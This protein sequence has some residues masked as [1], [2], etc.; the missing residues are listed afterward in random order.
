MVKTQEDDQK[1]RTRELFFILGQELRRYTTTHPGGRIPLVLSLENIMIRKTG[2]NPT[3]SLKLIAVVVSG[4]L[5]VYQYLGLAHPCDLA[6]DRL[7]PCPHFEQANGKAYSQDHEKVPGDRS[8][9]N[10]FEEL[11]LAMTML[12]DV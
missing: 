8:T 5:G 4:V 12:M 10:A 11:G 7:W 6:D 3:S 9:R 2:R 1:K